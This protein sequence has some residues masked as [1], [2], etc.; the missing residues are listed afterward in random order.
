MKTMVSDDFPIAQ[1]IT[2]EV[3]RYLRRQLLVRK[4]FLPGSFIRENEVAAEL[5]VSRSPVR[6]ALK[7]LE[8]YGIVKTLPRRGALVLQYSDE[9]VDEIY[10]VRVLLDM[11]VYERI[12][13]QR[14]MTDAHYDYLRRCIDKYGEMRSVF[15][16]S[17]VEGQLEFF[18]LECRFHF[19]IHNISGLKWTTEL[20][21][22]TYSRLFQYMIYNVEPED[23]PRIYTFHLNI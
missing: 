19:Y 4:R 16:K 12:V 7:V 2:E 23:L 15:E 20:L 21:K 3:A 8:S 1:S 17:L 10:N 13:K 6:E 5:N 9:D 11:Q 14:L 22:K 18:D